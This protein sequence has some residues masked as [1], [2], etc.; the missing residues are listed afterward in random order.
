[1]SGEVL[2][3]QR[4]ILVGLLEL[5]RVKSTTRPEIK[6]ADKLIHANHAVVLFLVMAPFGFVLLSLLPQTEPASTMFRIIPGAA[7]NCLPLNRPL[8]LRGSLKTSVSK[9][10]LASWHNI[11]FAPR[12]GSAPGSGE[13]I[14]KQHVRHF[15]IAVASFSASA[16]S[17][18]R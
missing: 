4:R 17:A 10:Q 14:C 15:L 8:S 9:Y 6:K 18:G 16:E 13:Q 2:A 12:S 11:N 7:Q 3:L 5:P 1:M